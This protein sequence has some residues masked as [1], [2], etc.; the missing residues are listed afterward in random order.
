MAIHLRADDARRLP[1][2]NGLGSTLEIASDAATRDG[3]WTWRLSIADVPSNGPFS[4]FEGVDRLIA[5][6]EGSGMSLRL[7]DAVVAVPT[8]GDAAAFAGEVE[9]HGALAAGAVRD[10]NLMVRRDHWTATLWLGRGHV[11][12]A[13]PACAKVLTHLISGTATV[14]DQDGVGHDLDVGDTLLVRDRAVTVRGAGLLAVGTLHPRL[15]T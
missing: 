4:L 6:V 15:A 9:V 10:I 2:K 11:E 8:E 1:W 13:V 3:S 14:I 7:P 12:R 5:C